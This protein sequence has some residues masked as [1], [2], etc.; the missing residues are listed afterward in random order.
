MSIQNWVYEADRAF[1]SCKA[2]F[3]DAS[4]NGSEGGC[5]GRCFRRELV[6]EIHVEK[7]KEEDILPP[8]RPGMPLLKIKTLSPTAETSGYALPALL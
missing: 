3:V 2:N 1:T 7:D 5:R 8:M 6:S 4:E